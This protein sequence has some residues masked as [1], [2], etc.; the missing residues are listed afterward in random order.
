[1][2]SLF[3]HPSYWYEYEVPHRERRDGHPNGKMPDERDAMGRVERSVMSKHKFREDSDGNRLW[4][5]S[6]RRKGAKA[7]DSCHQN[8]YTVLAG[9]NCG[10]MRKMQDIDA[11][12]RARE[13]ERRVVQYVVDTVAFF[14]THYCNWEQARA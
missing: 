4:S 13:L 3:D 14:E 12:V 11:F 1:M 8:E 6:Y 10:V 9:W 2:I 5:S 7:R